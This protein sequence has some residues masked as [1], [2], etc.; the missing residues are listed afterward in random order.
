MAIATVAGIFVCM[1][2]VPREIVSENYRLPLRHARELPTRLS[3]A[4]VAG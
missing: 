3:L 2:I 4:A 1:E